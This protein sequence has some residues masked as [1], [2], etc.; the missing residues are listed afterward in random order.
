MG[1]CRQV[2]GWCSGMQRSAGTETLCRPGPALLTVAAAFE[3]L[4]GTTRPAP[5]DLHHH[6]HRLDMRCSRKHPAGLG[7]HLLALKLCRAHRV[8]LEGRVRLQGGGDRGGHVSAAHECGQ[9]MGMGN[10]RQGA[11]AAQAAALL[12]APTGTSAKRAGEIPQPGLIL[13]PLVSPWA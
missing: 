7:A 4:G 8:P 13:Q 11:A 6:C 12:I 3:Q 2:Q 5:T 1:A 9:E 10:G